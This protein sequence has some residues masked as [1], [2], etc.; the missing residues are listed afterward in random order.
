MP[1]ESMLTSMTVAELESMKRDLRTTTG[2]AAPGSAVAIAA[3]RQVAQV[4]AE[5]S[6][7]AGDPQL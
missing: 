2:L 1:P 7:R 4:D 6:K 5:L 3:E